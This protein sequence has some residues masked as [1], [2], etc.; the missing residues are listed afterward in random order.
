LWGG[1]AGIGKATGTNMAF[2]IGQWCSWRKQAQEV[3][4]FTRI[5]LETRENDYTGPFKRGDK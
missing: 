4:A 5:R 2:Q 3:N 1:Y